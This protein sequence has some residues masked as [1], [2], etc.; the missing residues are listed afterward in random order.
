MTIA[1]V[2]KLSLICAVGS[3]FLNAKSA[4]GD[5]VAAPSQAAVA[6]WIEELRPNGVAQP[7][8][9]AEQLVQRDPALVNVTFPATDAWGFEGERPLHY[10]LLTNRTDWA[11]WLL[12]HGASIELTDAR[13]RTALQCAIEAATEDQYFGV[14]LCVAA[15]RAKPDQSHSLLVNAEGN[16]LAHLLAQRGLIAPIIGLGL[17]SDWF[18]PNWFAPNWFAPNWFAPNNAGIT[19]LQS[20][21]MFHSTYARLGHEPRPESRRPESQR[22]RLLALLERNEI[23]ARAANDLFVQVFLGDAKAVE[24]LTQTKLEMVNL[25]VPLLKGWTRYQEGGTPLALSV[26]LGHLEIAKILLAHGADAGNTSAAFSLLAIAVSDGNEAMA[27]L[28][29]DNGADINQRFSYF[30]A[31]RLLDIIGSQ[32]KDKADYKRMREWLLA[33][34]AKSVFDPAADEL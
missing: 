28:L 3:L 22:P 17:G 30:Y 1:S 10:A 24:R 23:K 12:Q 4:H 27:Q 14:Q 13:G 9:R 11:L 20:V 29:L 34:G 19:P 18:A 21:I 26:E 25:R 6:Q 8:T 2:L 16:T 31:S 5:D 33:H 15:L 7:F 32:I